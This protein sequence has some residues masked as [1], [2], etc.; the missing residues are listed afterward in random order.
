MTLA[1]L[2]IAAFILPE[3]QVVILGGLST[4]NRNDIIYAVYPDTTSFYQASVVEMTRN[5]K[6]K[7]PL[8]LVQ[9]KDDGDE[10]GITHAKAV[11]MKHV[12][13]VPYGAI[14]A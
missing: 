5:N 10:H 9:F 6:G 4:L 11:P 3:S 12:M 13:K 7:D 2:T 8:V 14:Q 1:T